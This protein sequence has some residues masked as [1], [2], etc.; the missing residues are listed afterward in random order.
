MEA[1]TS[2]VLRRQKSQESSDPAVQSVPN[3]PTK[4]HVRKQTD[5]E[6]RTAIA[7][8]IGGDGYA[9]MVTAILEAESLSN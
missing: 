5:A 4:E 7:N 6:R 9:R 8:H 1:S 3:K 2:T